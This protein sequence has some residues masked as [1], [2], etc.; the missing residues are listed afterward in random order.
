MT[1]LPLRSRG[2]TSDEH[3]LQ[4]GGLQRMERFGPLLGSGDEIVE[5]G[6]EPADAALLGK[7]RK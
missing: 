3:A 1:V 2:K 6:E 7:G 5:G 4:I